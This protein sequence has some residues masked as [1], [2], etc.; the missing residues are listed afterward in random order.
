MNCNKC[1]TEHS[2]TDIIDANFIDFK[3][4]TDCADNVVIEH[5]PFCVNWDI[6]EVE[7]MYE[8]LLMSQCDVV[9]II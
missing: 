4:I 1:K 5:C 7:D 3:V 9:G 6:C 8:R 2:D